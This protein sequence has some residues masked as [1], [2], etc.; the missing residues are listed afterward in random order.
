MT[1]KEWFEET[2]NTQMA[3][4]NKLHMDKGRLSRIL[5]GDESPTLK[6]AWDIEKLTKGKVKMHVWI[7]EAKK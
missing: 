2:N 5:S 7:D 3:I 4:A 6:Q 1:F